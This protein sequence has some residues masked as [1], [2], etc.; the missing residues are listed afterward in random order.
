MEWD[1]K[2]SIKYKRYKKYFLGGQI[3]SDEFK[4]K[5]QKYSRFSGKGHSI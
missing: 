1:G 3:R 5:N 4:S 2:Y